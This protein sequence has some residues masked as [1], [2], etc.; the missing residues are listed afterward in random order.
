MPSQVG[1]RDAVEYYVVVESENPCDNLR[2]Y[3]SACF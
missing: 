1:L 3:E 2:H